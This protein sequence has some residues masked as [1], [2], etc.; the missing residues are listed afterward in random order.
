[1]YI[2]F[3]CLNFIKLNKDLFMKKNKT[4]ILSFGI[5]LSKTVQTHNEVHDSAEN[6]DD[7]DFTV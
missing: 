6:D 2:A 1:M 3:V 4:V 5:A 7:N